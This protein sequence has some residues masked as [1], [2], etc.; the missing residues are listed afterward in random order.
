MR[1]ELLRSLPSAV[2][3]DDGNIDPG[4]TLTQGVMLF[5]LWRTSLQ[6][7]GRP[8]KPLTVSVF[9]PVLF[10]SAK[11]VVVG[12]VSMYQICAAVAD[13]V[14]FKYK[15]TREACYMLLSLH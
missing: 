11:I 1:P 3:S 5:G 4:R 8:W 2:F 12:N 10:S 15:E 14:G 13:H 7:N 6:H 9:L